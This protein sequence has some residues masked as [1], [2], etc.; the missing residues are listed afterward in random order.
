M[1]VLRAIVLG[2]VFL[3]L[4]VVPFM[5]MASPFDR[6][7]DAVNNVAANIVGSSAHLNRMNQLN[8]VLHSIYFPIMILLILFIIGWVW[9][10]ANKEDYVTG[11]M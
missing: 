7:L 10:E 5:I 9:Y 2:T 1:R 3:I 8:T 11:P 4:I 6:V